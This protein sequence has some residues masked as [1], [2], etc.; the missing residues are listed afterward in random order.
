MRKH[1]NVCICVSL[2]CKVHKMIC[3]TLFGFKGETRTVRIL[4]TAYIMCI[5]TIYRTRVQHTVYY[6][7]TYYTDI[8]V[9]AGISICLQG[10]YLTQALQAGCNKYISHNNYILKSQMYFLR[11]SPAQS[12]G[13]KIAYLLQY[14]PY[15][16]N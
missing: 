9:C 15:P 13:E 10:K 12:L 6:I 5:P 3:F 8:R 16:S 11:F 2:Y 7:Y 1:Q 14:Y 4:Y